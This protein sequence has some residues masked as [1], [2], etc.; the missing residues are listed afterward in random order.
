MNTA[1]TEQLVTVARA[2]RAAGHGSRGAIYQKACSEL[3]MSY[4]T[5]QRKLKEITVTDKRKKRTDAGQTALTREDALMI[6]ALLKES[7]RKNGK[8]LMSVDRAIEILRSNEQIKAEYLDEET[9]EIRP[10]SVST[11]HRALRTYGLHPDQ[12]NAPAPV[13]ELQSLH[14]NHVWQIDAS[15]CTL[16][17]LSNGLQ[18]MAPEVYYKNK[19]GNIERISANRVWRY[20]ITDHTSGWLYVEYVLGAESGENLCSVLINAMQERD[21][22]DIM[23]GIPRKLMLDPGAANTAGMTKNLCH[24]LG[25]ELIVNKVGNARAKGQVENAN[26]LVETQLEPG[27]KLQC[28]NGLDALNDIAR[29]WRIHFNATQIHGRTGKTRHAAWMMIKPDQLIKAPSLEICRELAVAQPESRKVSPTLQ[30]SFGGKQYDVSTVPNVMVGEKIMVTRNP[31]RDDA[32]QVVLFDEDGR[33]VFHVVNEIQKNEF[34]FREDAAVIGESFKRHADTP[35]QKAANEIE[36]LVT[37]TD[38][39]TAAEA[40]RKAKK[41]PFGGKI[42]PFKH[43]D[44]TTLPTFLPR[45]GTEHGLATPKI[46]FPP[47]SHV[48]AAKQLRQLLAAAGHEWTADTFAWLQQRYPESVPQ[49]DLDAI[50]GQ[51][52]RKDIQQTLLKVVGGQL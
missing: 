32:A 2:A 5:L 31:W 33:E 27:L 46:E 30:I 13:T 1:V 26:N 3:G 28:V 25:I 9:G 34:G 39:V 42:D 49:E 12:L 19:P 10:L 7:F 22:Q 21:G 4:A 23:H 47:L 14:P 35:A 52:T 40:F 44:E 17:Y 48:E 38:S 45:R 43:I 15:L 51:L 8:K 11:V 37:E 36:Q 20:V 24:A 6:S 41:L 50:V 16:Y 29:K 18:G